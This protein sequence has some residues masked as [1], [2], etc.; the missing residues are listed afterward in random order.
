MD[1]YFFMLM[2]T[3]VDGFLTPVEGNWQ[4]PLCSVIYVDTVVLSFKRCLHIYVQVENDKSNN[5]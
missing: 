4:C 5:R 3:A 1:Q 2:C